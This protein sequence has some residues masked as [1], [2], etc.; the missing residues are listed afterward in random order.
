MVHISTMGRIRMLY[1][2]AGLS[3]LVTFLCGFFIVPLA[4]EIVLTFFGPG[5]FTPA[6]F[7]GWWN[8]GL[9]L[10]AASLVFWLVVSH[11]RHQAARARANLIVRART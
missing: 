6:P 7:I 4:Q 11:R 2:G 9:S 3:A 1:V 10:L 5:E 8:T